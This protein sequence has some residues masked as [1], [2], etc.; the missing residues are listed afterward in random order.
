MTNRTWIS[1]IV[2]VIAMNATGTSALAAT[3]GGAT[4]CACG[5]SVTS[6]YTMTADLDCSGAGNNTKNG[7]DVGSN[8]VLDCA[9]FSVIGG[10][11]VGKYGLRIDTKNG[12]TVMSCS[13]SHFE[14]GIRVHDSYD[15]SIQEGDAS[16]NL[17][18]GVEVSDSS[19]APDTTNVTV[20]GILA[21]ANGDEGIHVSGRSGV[22]ANH[23]IIG[24]T[25]VGQNCEGIYILDIDGVSGSNGVFVSNNNI[26]GNG[27]G[28]GPDNCNPNAA[29]LYIHNSDRNSFRYNSVT[30]DNIQLV[31]SSNNKFLRNAVNFGT[32]K[33]GTGSNSN[34]FSRDCTLGNSTDP[35]D[36][37]VFDASTGNTCA[38]CAIVQPQTHQIVASNGSTGTSFT[39]LYIA[40]GTLNNSVDGT[41]GLTVTT[42]ATGPTCVQ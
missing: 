40:S 7:L 3:C 14:I 33:L 2:A 28:G 29:G 23:R 24:N 39:N 13:V 35:T 41:S 30:H 1:A 6:D 10:D 20:L 5:D 15:V 8:V 22:V 27:L 36:G 11:V 18:Y 17:Q 21:F 34:N 16:M 37:F 42:S 31:G 4:A 9:G 19:T 25:V 12:V 32:I 26:W 38:T